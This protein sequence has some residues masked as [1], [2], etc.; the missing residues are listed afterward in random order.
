[1]TDDETL[2]QD[3]EE[4]LLGIKAIAAKHGIPRRQVRQ[5]LLAAGTQIRTPG[6]PT[7]SKAPRVSS[8]APGAGR[9]KIELDLDRLKSDYENGAS[10]DLL[11]ARH[12]VSAGT[13][14]SRLKDAGTTMRRAVP[15]NHLVGL[16]YDWGPNH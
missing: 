8:R 3:Y 5:R 10:V 2:R 6:K 15:G 1:M 12:G 13:I 4:N 7:G 16:S 11:A 9:P 14:R